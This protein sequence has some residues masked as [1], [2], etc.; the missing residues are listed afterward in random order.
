L[1]YKRSYF[2]NEEIKNMI[3]KIVRS[4]LVLAFLVGSIGIG[5]ALAGN[6]FR[7]STTTEGGYTTWDSDLINIEAVSETGS[8]VYVAVLDTGLV[9]N[10]ADY[11]PSERVNTSLGTGFDQPVAFTAL[12]DRCGLGINVGTLHQTTWVGSTGSTHGTHVASTILGYFY[13]SNSDAAAGYP[14]PPIVVR[15]IAPNVT[16]IPVKVLADYQ[17][18]ALPKCDPPA[19][20]QKVVFGTDEMVA[21]A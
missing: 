15:G 20:A 13:R 1:I 7:D 21:A 3:V 6:P 14:L 5:T 19:R 11:F 10:W 12:N 16:I 4:I 9:P 8:G 18:P 2:N 17:V